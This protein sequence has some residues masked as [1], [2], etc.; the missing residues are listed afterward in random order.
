MKR[1]IELTVEINIEKIVKGSEGRR[2]AFSLLNKRLRKE[3]QD[4]EREFE[5]KKIRGCCDGCF[6]SE[7]CTRATT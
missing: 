4:L 3:R 1:K 7:T 2:D 5:K 6:S